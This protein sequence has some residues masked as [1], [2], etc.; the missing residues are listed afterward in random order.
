MTDRF[1]LIVNAVSKK[2]EEL[3]AGDSLDLT[4]NGIVVSGDRGVG[5]YL[6]SDGV[7]VFW[8]SPGDVYLDQTQTV[9]NKTFESCTLSGTL[10]TIT[11]LPNSALLNSK[12]TINGTAVSLGQSIN[13]PNDNTTYSISAVDGLS[14]ST[15]IIRLTDSSSQTDDVSI[16]VGSPVS[17]PAGS[18]ALSLALNRTGDTITI[19]G[20]VVDNNTVTTVQSATGGSPVSGAITIAAGAFTTVTQTGN[21][22]TVIGQN[23]DT[24]TSLRA[25]TGNQFAFGNVTFLQGGATTLTQGVDGN[26][27][28]TI[29]VSSSDTITRL[30]GGGSGTF[31]SGDVTVTGGNALGGNVQVSQSGNTIEID[32]TDTNTVTQLAVGASGTLSAGDFRF[33]QAGATTISS[34][35]DGGTGVTTFT[36]SSENSDTGAGLTAGDGLILDQ[37]TFKLKNASNLVTNTVAKWDDGNG[38]LTNSIITDNGS[39]VTIGGDLQV[40]GTQTILNTSVLQ[41]EDNII[42]L[43]K[44][45]NLVAGDGGIQVNMTSN[46]DG[47]IL[48]YKQLQWYQAGGYWRSYDGSVDNRFV[49]EN[50][51]QVLTNKTLTSP[52]LTSPTLGAATADSLN[53]LTITSTASATLDIASAKE[54]DVNQN[55][56]LTSD[57]P[58][59]Y[60]TANFRLGGNVAYTT[61]TLATFAQTTAVQLRGMITGTTGLDN[62]VFQTNPT[63]LTGISTTSTGFNLINSGATSIQFGGTAQAIDMGEAGGTTTIRHSL[64]VEESTTLGT[65]AND[66]TVVLSTFNVDNVDI[67]IRGTSSDPMRVGRGIGEVS[68][69][70]AVGVRAIQS[71]SS[72]SQNTAFGY[73]AI[74]A[75]NTGASNTAVGNRALRATGVGS[76]NIAIGSDCLLTNLDGSMNVAVGN[77]ALESNSSGNANVCIGHYAGYN[78]NGTG[79]VLIG[80]ADDENSTNATFQPPSPAG[81]RQLVIGSG[82]EAWIRGNSDFKVT[83]PGEFQVIG[84][85]TIGGSL[86]VN[87]TLTTINSNSISVD[88]KEIELASVEQNV[89]FN[90]STTNGSNVVTGVTPTAGFIP[91]MEVISLTNGISVPAGTVI[92]TINGNEFTLTQSVSGDGTATFESPGASDLS[93]DQGGIRIK[94]TTD[95]RIYYD[96]SR[97]DKYWVM[98]ENLELAF[99]KKMVIGNQLVISTTDLGSTVVNSSLTSVGTLTNLTIDGFLTIG[100]V[101]TEKVFNSFTTA[102][103]PSSNV[104]TIN[105][106]GANTICGTPA[107]QAIDEWEFTGV[108]LSNGQSKTITLILS[109]NTSAI[110]GDAC[111]V[112]GS[113]ITNGVQ[114][115][116][117]SPPVP[118]AN[119]DI[120]TFIIVRDNS[121]VVKVFG[122]G[123]TDF[124]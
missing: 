118:T 24:I 75:A 52:T 51:A 93:A 50:E 120:L 38:Q 39:V 45:D 105:L 64:D 71:V 109:A 1:P 53:G 91:G 15:K 2:V 11:N 92:Q 55:L 32:S 98:T 107:A 61:D 99:G 122:Q 102:L 23:D 90:A 4:G 76:K 66:N 30:K 42:E 79:N 31:V 29:T 46:S 101:V 77:N 43:R 70:T 63:I 60:I 6:A 86:V 28:A 9:T 88:D 100:G 49:T 106:A 108:N 110:Y 16:A 113:G 26:G 96:H 33:V 48:S 87:G 21:T 67:F 80:P 116:G 68:T 47:A 117:G 37:G 124:S 10:N 95:K 3:V 65:D 74:F 121:G 83:I 12:I 5:K 17:V 62:L 123:N 114:W 89:Q 69:N 34:S 14:S 119:T 36:I 7:T 85:T 84:D 82:T 103:T 56:I 59:G 73:E 22:I 41:I 81:N 115:A 78:M 112:D 97:T 72:G 27:D 111:T 44:G 40:E 13:T 19:S 20:T 57:N 58:T 25:G 8:S 35:I 18:N 54:L 104:L 94:G